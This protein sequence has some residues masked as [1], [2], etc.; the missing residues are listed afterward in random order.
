MGATF[1]DLSPPGEERFA[2]GE[3]P[4]SCIAMIMSRLDS[5]EICQLAL[6]NKA[7]WR[8]STADLVWEPKLPSNYAFLARK[9]LDEMP[10]TKRELYARLCRPVRFDGGFKEVWVEKRSGKMCMSLSWKDLQITGIHDRRYWTQISSKE[11]RFSTIAYLR[12]IWWLE[13]R[14]NIEFTFPDG[15]YSLYFRLHMGKAT[16][17]R[18]EQVHGWNIKPVKFELWTSNEQHVASECYLGQVGNWVH[19]H[20]GDFVVGG[21]DK[22]T[23]IKFSM[24]QIDCTHSK[25]GLC[26]DSV[27]I[28]PSQLKPR[29]NGIVHELS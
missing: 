18:L 4:E 8:A 5:P 25:A 19:Y 1:S 3:L 27:L 13:A 17:G 9:L 7:F 10:E 14:G 28:Y 2:L 22:A 29:L 21:S 11:S 20:V 6:L 23:K 12:Q 16:K 26:I 15:S 24:T